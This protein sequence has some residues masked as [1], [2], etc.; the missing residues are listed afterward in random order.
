[1]DK[2]KIIIRESVQN[3]GTLSIIFGFIGV[4]FYHLYLAL[5]PLFLVYLQS[6]SMN[7]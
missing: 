1:M 4:L 3:Y 2:E 5:L 6:R 7:T